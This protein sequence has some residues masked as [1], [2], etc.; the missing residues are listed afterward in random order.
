[1][2]LF[3]KALHT[4]G[5]ALFVCAVLAACSEPLASPAR[6]IAPGGAPER[7]ATPVAGRHLFLLQG[8]VPRDF[9]ARVRAKGGT[10]IRQYDA[11]HVV[12]TTGLADADAAALAG[13]GSVAHDV[14]TRWIPTPAERDASVANLTTAT[15]A[16]VQSPFSAAFLAIQWNMFQIH[17]P[18]AW[19]RFTGS[20]TVRVAILDTGLDPFHPELQGLIDL[21]ASAY[22]V[23]ST[24]P[25]PAP[26]WTDDE[27]HG[28][29]VGG[30]VTSNN[31]GVA[32]VAPNVRLIAVKVLDAHGSGSFSD[33]VAGLVYAATPR[34]A[35]GA[36]ANV[37][38]ASLGATIPDSPDARVFASII[39]QYV[40]YAT[41]Q[42]ALL[43]SA[44]G[45][46][47]L[48]LGRPPGFISV[49]CQTGPQI[50]V[51]ATSVKDKLASYSNYGGGAIDVAAPGGDKHVTSMNV[52]DR[53]VLSLCST[54]AAFCRSG[55]T[56]FLY[57]FA[58]GTS[59]SAPHVSGLAALLDS[60]HGG[61][62]TPAQMMSLIKSNADDIGNASWYGDGR[63]NVARTLGVTS[64]AAG[65]V[66]QTP[67]PK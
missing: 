66:A 19:Q 56:I 44:A 16:A 9:A 57:A 45:N 24:A 35:G 7:A 2:S 11:I 63:I 43:V 60:Q 67:T 42:G 8:A 30:I 40:A 58:T 37:V 52:S 17:A 29:F 1:M 48:N 27:T 51:S 54:R 65:T 47:N 18:E 10:V 61:H 31:I 13:S 14:F 5:G 22:A 34:T 55:N 28:T 25:A 23:P 21:D 12:V 53:W 50:C 20:P 64:S 62:L 6:S 41:A 3:R 4:S 39:A 36:G 59:A 15:S 32:G 46:E 38:N 49:P 33:I 26:P